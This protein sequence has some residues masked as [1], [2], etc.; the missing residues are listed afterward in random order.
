MTD[1]NRVTRICKYGRTDKCKNRNNI[2]EHKSRCG[3]D[4]NKLSVPESANME[5]LTNVRIE[6]TYLNTKADIVEMATN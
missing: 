4:G 6:T 5:E 2:L 1:K 3:G